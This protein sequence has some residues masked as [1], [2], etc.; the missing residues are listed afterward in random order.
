VARRDGEPLTVAARKAPERA[1]KPQVVMVNMY[2]VTIDGVKQRLTEE[3]YQAH[4]ARA[5]RNMLLKFQLIDDEAQYNRTE[6]KKWMKEVHGEHWYSVGAISDIAGGAVP[7]PD[8]IWTRPAAA[9]A[10]GRKAAQEGRLEAAARQLQLASETLRDVRHEWHEYMGKTIGGAES[11]EKGLEIT[12]DVSFA[13]AISAA[14]IVAAPIVA[15]AVGT[16][17]TGA[18]ATGAGLTAVTFVGTTGA[19][20][21]GGGVAGGVLR[22]GTNLAGQALTGDKIRG[23]EVLAETWKG[24]KRGAVDAGSTVVGGATGELLGAGAKGI[25]FASRVTR[26]AGAGMAGGGFG[27]F[28]GSALDKIDDPKKTWGDVAHDTLTSAASG[29]LGGGSS[30]GLSHVIPNAP[31]LVQSLGG[32]GVGSLAAAGT[33]YLSGASPEEIKEAAITAGVQGFALSH[34]SHEGGF[35][36]G[37]GG[38][39]L[40]EQVARKKDEQARQLPQKPRAAIKEKTPSTPEEPKTPVEKEAEAKVAENPPPK[41]DVQAHEGVEPKEQ[42]APAASTKSESAKS[43]PENLFTPEEAHQ[44][45]EEMFSSAEGRP[46]VPTGVESPAVK[47]GKVEWPEAK[48]GEVRRTRVP[49]GSVDAEGTVHRPGPA[50]G[51]IENIARLPGET[52]RQAVKR[53]NTVNGQPISE[54]PLSSAWEQARAKVLK[55]RT[56]ESLGADGALVAYKRTQQEFWKAVRQDPAAVQFL[57]DAGF[58]LPKGKGAA[59]LKVTQ[60]QPGQKGLIVEERRISLDHSAEKAIGE[61]WKLA[62]DS[63]KLIFEFHRVN[64]FRDSLQRAHKIGAYAPEPP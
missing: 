57:Q 27:G 33:A 13:I 4:R 49:E 6:H 11:T 53:V 52:Q 23:R 35:G 47:G 62:L 42:P 39:D 59:L 15:G 56:V 10:N 50:R 1:A 19:I 3:Q 17:A 31:K 18:G 58:V 34:A 22:G 37:E 38:R 8:S 5:L 60:P 21:V 63:D 14:A 12:R 64:S 20:T 7:P 61:N 43:D 44:H 55:G 32:A 45:V 26:G 28:V 25:G 48:T 46:D 54:T 36:F 2:E 24:A 40:H 16:A 51:D 29:I 30:A 41:H 9:I